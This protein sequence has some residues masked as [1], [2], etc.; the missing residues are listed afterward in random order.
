M[1]CFVSGLLRSL[2]N[3]L[4]FSLKKFEVLYCVIFLK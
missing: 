4:F 3:N 2:Q 1:N